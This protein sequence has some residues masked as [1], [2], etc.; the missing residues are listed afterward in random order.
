VQH[1]KRDT[2]QA[3]LQEAGIHTQI[4]YPIPP[5]LQAAYKAMG[6]GEGRFPIAEAMSNQ[7]L[8]LPMGPQLDSASVEAVIGALRLALRHL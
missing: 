4:H 6:Y 1:P 8:S 2:L 5:H 7:L 3:E